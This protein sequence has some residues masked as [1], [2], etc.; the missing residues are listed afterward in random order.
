MTTIITRLTGAWV[1]ARARHTYQRT[2]YR[3]AGLMVA[4][5]LVHLVAWLVDG[6][7]W[8]GPVSWRKPIVFSLSFAL[9][10]L[11]IGWVLGRLPHRR[12]LGWATT[13]LV[14]GGGVV[15]VILIAGQRWRGVASHFNTATALDATIFTLM[16]VAIGTLVTGLLLL[17][18]WAALRVPGAT[19]RTAALAGLVLMLVGSAIGNDLIMRGTATVEATGSVPPSVVIGAGGSGKLAHAVALHGLQVLAVLALLLDRTPRAER[20]APCSRSAQIY[21]RR[22]ATKAATQARTSS[23]EWAADS[24]TRIRALPCGTTG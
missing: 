6:G 3:L 8:E 16:A 19:D 12:F 13:A 11:S 4:S 23:S 18:V 5:T 17:T 10:F 2:M 7:A 24:C 22:V 1:D 9:T 21:G 20:R 15:E 14:G